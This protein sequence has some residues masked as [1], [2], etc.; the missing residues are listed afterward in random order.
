[1]YLKGTSINVEGNIVTT[2]DITAKNR[3]ILAELDAKQNN[4]GTEPKFNTIK[5]D[6][7]YLRLRGGSTGGVAIYDGLAVNNN[8]GINVGGNWARVAT[9][10]VHADHFHS[11]GNIVAAGDITAKNRNIL[12]ELDGK[13]GGDLHGIRFSR[14]WTGYPDG[15]TDGAEIA[16]DTNQYK[17][18]MIVGNKSAGGSRRVS[19]WDRLEVNG[20][21][22]IAA[23]DSLNTETNTMK[24][25][26]NIL[27]NELHDLKK[28][29][30][31]NT[32]RISV[33]HANRKAC[34]GI[35]D[36]H[37]AFVGS[38]WHSGGVGEYETFKITRL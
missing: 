20:R 31:R 19:V 24:N 15:R 8:G 4:L 34:L 26:I 25:N 3:N 7:D 18:L 5:T 27:N 32:D 22:I 16:N 14:N 6:G 10:Q 1:M 2:G 35:D 29:A 21:D 13:V 28:N 23:I 33:C 12:A 9:G 11:R 38:Y 37:R 30:V 36:K 17:T